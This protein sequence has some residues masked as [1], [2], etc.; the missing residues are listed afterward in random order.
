MTKL[1][2]LLTAILYLFLVH[3][4]MGLRPEHLL[5][6]GFILLAYTLHPKTRRWTLDFLPFALFAALYDF[7]RIIPKGW[8]GPIHVAWPYRLESVLFGFDVDGVRTIPN[9]F[10]RLHHHPLLDLV[11]GLAYSLHMVVPIGFGI[12]AWV[13]E[14]DRGIARSFAWTFLLAN[15]FA[16]ATYIA[17]P[18]APPWYV[19]QYGLAPADW[20][21]PASAAGL[22]NFDRLLGINYFR[23]MYAKSSWVFGAIPSMHA[24]L[25]LLVILFARKILKKGMI[26][27]ALF[28]AAVWFSAVYLRHHYL[29]DLVAGALYAIAAFLA[30]ALLEKKF[31]RGTD[32]R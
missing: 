19:E 6:T 9:E 24:G 7:L 30:A 11:C 27:L 15:L 29:I 3:F 2:P 31:L 22:L 21:T 16:F 20:S 23:D 13:H 4:T 10:F 32:V 28:M 1:L 17:L 25:P 18:V 12:F 14:K 5:L 8:A 26:L